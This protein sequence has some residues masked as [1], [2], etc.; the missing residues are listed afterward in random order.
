MRKSRLFVLS[1]GVSLFASVG[2]LAPSASAATDPTRVTINL[3]AVV[4]IVDGSPPP[5]IAPGVVITGSYTYN[6]KTKD[7][8]PLVGV[9]DYVHNQQPY[10]IQ[11]NMGDFSVQTDPEN[12]DFQ[13]EIVNDYNGS[14]NYTLISFNNTAGVDIIHWQLNDPTQAALSN[15]N[16]KKTAPVLSS[17]EQPSQLDVIGED[18]AYLIR[19]HVTQAVKVA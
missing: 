2:L 19:S 6:P 14:D 7:I 3:T 5:G 8:N 13:I 9:G 16:L 12:V 17:W 11:L 1:V 15:A 10:G 18:D 4:D